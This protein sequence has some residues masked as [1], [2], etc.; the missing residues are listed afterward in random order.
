[1]HEGERFESTTTTIRQRECLSLP[2]SSQVWLVSPASRSAPHKVHDL[3]WLVASS[4]FTNNTY[5]LMLTINYHSVSSI[6]WKNTHRQRG[7]R[8]DC[9]A[10]GADGKQFL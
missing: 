7:R 9:R 5:P 8:G 4:H 2:G 10:V 1:V 3:D 6:K